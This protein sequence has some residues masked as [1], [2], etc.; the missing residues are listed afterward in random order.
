[1]RKRD[2]MRESRNEKERYNERERERE[3]MHGAPYTNKEMN[4]WIGQTVKHVPCLF[5]IIFFG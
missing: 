1:M 3:L 5:C 2:I 4:N